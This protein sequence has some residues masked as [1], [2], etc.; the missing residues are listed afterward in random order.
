MKITQKFKNKSLRLRQI[1][2]VVIALTALKSHGQILSNYI[3]EAQKNSPKIEAMRLQYKVSEEKVNQADALP[4]TKFG[5]GYFLSTPET[6]VG[7]QQFKVSAMQQLPWF[8]TLT[9][10]ENYAE[11]LTETQYQKLAIA[12]RQLSLNLSQSFYKLYA[13]QAKIK[14][15]NQNI[16][17]LKTYRELALSDVAN[18]RASSVDVMRLRI[19]QNDL[20]EKRE[21]LT[22][23]FQAEAGNFNQFLNREIQQTPI[24]PDTLILPNKQNVKVENLKLHP[25]LLQYEKMY[26]EVEKSEAVN[27]KES[28]PGF[29][30]G[31]N[32]IQVQ[33]RPQAVSDNGKDILMPVVSLSIPIFNNRYSSISK[34]HELQ[35]KRI[36]AEKEN[37]LQE[38]K[39][40][41]NTAF[42]NQGSARTTI[43]IQNKNIK[44]AKDAISILN[45]QYETGE[46]DYEEILDVQELQLKI[47]L[48]KADA[49]QYFFEQYALLNYLSPNEL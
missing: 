41:T 18:D 17:L 14:V 19:R 29:G 35:Q 2:F 46:L 31:L 28:A 34:E 13:F 39:S 12:K 26:D 42:Q 48:K 40:M 21:I 3:T 47:Q 25:E 43:E 16:E 22:Q 6:R 20:V 32:Y 7:P 44:Q 5:A 30:V 10:R 27:Q 45:R 49:V 15:V 23:N 8:G 24:L 1:L 37:R 33:E 9:A 38:L 4:D 11:S 36:E